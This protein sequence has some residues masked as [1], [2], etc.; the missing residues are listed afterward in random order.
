VLLA[1]V[2]G[3]LL[4][5]AQLAAVISPYAAASTPNGP[6]TSSVILSDDVEQEE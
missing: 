1:V 6:G 3:S 5:I 4:W 2:L